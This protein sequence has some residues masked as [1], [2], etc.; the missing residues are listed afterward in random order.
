[1]E[2]IADAKGHTVFVRCPTSPPFWESACHCGFRSLRYHSKEDAVDAGLAHVENAT[3]F[4]VP[5][6]KRKKAAKKTARKK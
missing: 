2:Q 3:V 4:H 1:M 5:P 6:V